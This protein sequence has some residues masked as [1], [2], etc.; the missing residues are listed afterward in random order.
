MPTRASKLSLAIVVI[1][2]IN[3]VLYINFCHNVSSLVT[4]VAVIFEFGG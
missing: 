1:N 4:K 3:V 2:S